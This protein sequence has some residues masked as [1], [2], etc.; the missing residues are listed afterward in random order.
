MFVRTGY[1]TGDPALI[2]GALEALDTEAVPLL[3]A[4]PG[5]RGFGL[6]ANRELGV[7]LMGSWWATAQAESDSA[8]RL[9]ARRDELL[10]PF[11]G[12][13]AVEVT[14]AAVLSPPV[15]AGPGAGF[16]LARFDF[17]PAQGDRLAG[18]FRE[19]ALPALQRVDGFV[20]AAMLLNRAV[21]HGSVGVVF[22]D[23]AAL[24]ASR[25][26]QAEARARS[27]AASG[28]VIRSLEEFD[29]IRLNRA[30][31]P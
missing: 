29:V 11:A 5:Y 28:A 7:V 27:A 24:A 31:Q 25:G 18:A 3:S 8:G 23:R 12:T 14:E 20:S 1:F 22:A 16:R 17:D 13:A 10:A 26:P 15:P 9:R 30:A 6:F 4:Q 19:H 2:G 21:G